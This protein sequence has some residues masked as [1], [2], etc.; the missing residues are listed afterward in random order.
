[1]DAL[2]LVFAISASQ[3]D[4]AMQLPDQH[5]VVGRFAN[6]IAGFNR[7]VGWVE[8]DKLISGEQNDG[9]GCVAIT[10]ST[11]RERDKAMAPSASNFASTS[12]SPTAST[13]PFARYAR[14]RIHPVTFVDADQAHQLLK[15]KAALTASPT[16]APQ[17]PILNLLTWCSDRLAG[18]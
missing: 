5:I 18:S 12:A 6:S 14:E 10:G 7:F 11:E 13:S 8:R 3:V 9:G 15:T 1:M 17:E 2:I 16:P 4:V